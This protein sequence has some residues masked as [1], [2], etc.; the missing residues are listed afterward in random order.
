VHDLEQAGVRLLGNSLLESVGSRSVQVRHGEASED[1]RTDTVI[2]ASGEVPDTRLVT[3]LR[4][5]GVPVRAVGDCR[6]V[7]GLEGANHDALDV[8]LA[9]A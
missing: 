9:L 8:A 2:L 7:R 5:V 6:E 1:V 3:A 4:G